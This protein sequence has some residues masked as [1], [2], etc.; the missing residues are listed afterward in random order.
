MTTIGLPEGESRVRASNW[1]TRSIQLGASCLKRSFAALSCSLCMPSLM[2]CFPSTSAFSGPWEPFSA[3]SMAEY[4]LTTK[5]R[6]VVKAQGPLPRTDDPSCQY[7]SCRPFR[8]TSSTMM[9]LNSRRHT[10]FRLRTSLP[11]TPWLTWHGSAR[12]ARSSLRA[13]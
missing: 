8:I 2:V 7:R 12:C 11:P 4:Y 6:R 13:R 1:W 10:R 3:I 9:L 5:K